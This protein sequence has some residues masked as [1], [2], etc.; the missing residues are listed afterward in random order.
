MHSRR[1]RDQGY[2]NL[3]T[4]ATLEVFTQGKWP[5][6]GVCNLL[7]RGS[8]IPLGQISARLSNSAAVMERAVPS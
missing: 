5:F 3:A 1:D 8:T 6:G 4:R 2:R 7:Q